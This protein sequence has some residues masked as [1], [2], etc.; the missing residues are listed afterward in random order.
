[1][2]VNRL[3]QCIFTFLYFHHPFHL[4]SENLKLLLIKCPCFLLLGIPNVFPLAM[5]IVAQCCIIPH[6]G[7]PNSG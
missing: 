6:F 5:Q 7:N 1:M 2:Q 4:L 3:S